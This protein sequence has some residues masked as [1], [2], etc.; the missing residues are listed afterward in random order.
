MNQLLD[1]NYLG[2]HT[3]SVGQVEIYG[4]HSADQRPRLEQSEAV[5]QDEGVGE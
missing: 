5:Y 4:I 1:A 2:V 3:L